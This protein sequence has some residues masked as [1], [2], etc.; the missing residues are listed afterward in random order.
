MQRKGKR[1]GFSPEIVAR[2]KSIL[3]SRKA[4]AEAEAEKRLRQLHE[5]IPELRE[6]DAAFPKLGASIVA[7]ASGGLSEAEIARQVEALK[8]ES[9]ELEEVRADCLELAGYPA[10]YTNPHYTCVK[11][12]DTGYV[13]G[14][15]CECMKKE[16]ILLGYENSGLGVLLEKQKFENFSL[17]YYEGDALS[18]MRYNFDICQSFAEGFGCGSGRSESMLFIGDTGLGKT[19]LSTAIAGRVIERGFDVRYETSQNLISVFSRQRFGRGYGE[20]Y[21]DD[22]SER[23]FGCDL[24]I[25]DDFGTEENNQF[26]VSVFYNLINTRINRGLPVI[27]NTNLREKEIRARYADR[28]TSRLFGEFIVL[29]FPGRD[30]RMQNLR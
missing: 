18:T 12:G 14:R 29:A 30:I 2:V 5:K 13:D 8:R 11:C 25:I 9:G 19:H 21:S 24:L 7:L 4:C 3:S 17:D 1:M 26:S 27:I 28:I 10:D 20:A 23:Y 6:I 16:C 15:M 22:A